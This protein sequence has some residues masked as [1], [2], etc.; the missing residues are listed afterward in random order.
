MLHRR[1]LLLA[2]VLFTSAGRAEQGSLL[3]CWI[4]DGDKGVVEMIADE[5]GVHGRIVGLEQPRFLEGEPGATPGAVRTDLAHPD[6]ALRDRP[7]PGLRLIE[8]LQADGDSWSDGTVYDPESG[9]AYALK[10]SLERDG[11][12]RLR[13]Y[14]GSP[15][16]GRTIHW[17][18]ASRRPALTRTL[19]A[20]TADLLPDGAAP[21]CDL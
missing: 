4:T 10:A 3:G 20:R 17:E 12:L 21:R 7:L 1:H 19:L 14:V 16:L 11:R 8:G 2:L 13:G 18:P 6:P 5:E 15:L 9:R